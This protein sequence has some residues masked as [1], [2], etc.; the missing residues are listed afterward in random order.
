MTQLIDTFELLFDTDD[1]F[2]KLDSFCLYL[3]EKYLAF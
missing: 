1:S 3:N 2:V